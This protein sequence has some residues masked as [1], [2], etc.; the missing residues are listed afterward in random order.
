M[1]RGH[2]VLFEGG[3]IELEREKKG[4]SCN[5]SR[6]FRCCQARLIASCISRASSKKFNLH[7]YIIRSS[8]K[9]MRCKCSLKGEGLSKQIILPLLVHVCSVMG[10][11]LHTTE[12][13][14]ADVP[15]CTNNVTKCALCE[16]K[17]KTQSQRPI[18]IWGCRAHT[19]YKSTADFR[20]LVV[21][22]VSGLGLCAGVV[23][24]L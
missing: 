20:S 18:S 8:V 9:K 15:Q 19:P 2:F 4:M 13:I 22:V 5:Y 3:T 16:R 7:R 17:T 21:M 1:T 14:R 24:T 6:A 10:R 23:Q 12:N 11:L